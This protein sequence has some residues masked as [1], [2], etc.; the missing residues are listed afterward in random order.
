MAFKANAF[1]VKFTS[2]TR[3]NIEFLS[4]I[5]VGISLILPVGTICQKK[6]PFCNGLMIHSKSFHFQYPGILF[7]QSLFTY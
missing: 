2:T 5:I 7:Y 3:E 6:R 4:C 1:L